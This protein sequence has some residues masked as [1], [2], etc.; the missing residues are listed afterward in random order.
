VRS[1]LECDGTSTEVEIKVTAGLISE[2]K[3]LN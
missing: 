2:I 3:F 1:N